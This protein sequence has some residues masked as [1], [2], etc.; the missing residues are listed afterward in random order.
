[1]EAREA[2]RR[3]GR[4]PGSETARR[5]SGPAEVVAER[6]ADKPDHHPRSVAGASGAAGL[7]AAMPVETVPTIPR[8]H[9]TAMVTH[10]PMRCANYSIG[11]IT[12]QSSPT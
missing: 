9:I 12:V 6:A 3:E 10:R 11:S 8:R 1:M 5:L 7:P 2:A 4:R